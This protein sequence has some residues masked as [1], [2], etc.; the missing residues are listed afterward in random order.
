MKVNRDKESL[1]SAERVRELFNYDHDTGHLTHKIRL[2]G[3]ASVG[4]VAGSINKKRGY[5]SVEIE[6]QQ[7]VIHRV[8]WLYVHGSWPKNQID[9]ING[10][11][12]DNRIAN[13]REATPQE[14]SW[15]IGLISTNKSG[16][17]GVSIIKKT[18]LFAAS[19]W[20]DG[21]RIH[22]GFFKSAEQASIV[23][24]KAIEFRGEFIPAEGR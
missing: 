5:R 13:L 9:H 24:Q 18:N 14:N 7:Y 4:K 20:R 10:D 1:L 16:Y 15:N 8:I 22:L 21:K 23:Y 19:V 2:G 6:D 11:R 3:R 12:Q 17:C